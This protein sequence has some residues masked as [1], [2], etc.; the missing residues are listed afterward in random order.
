MVLLA[1]LCLPLLQVPSA[2]DFMPLIVGT[3]WTYRETG[4]EAL[5]F[6]HTVESSVR[7]SGQVATPVVVR[8]QGSP[9]ST[10]Y[11]VVNDNTLGIIADDDLRDPYS[12]PRPVFKVAAET[13]NW[14][15]AGKVPFDSGDAPI[16]MTGSSRLGQKQTVLGKE[17]DTLEVTLD[18]TLTPPKKKPIMQHQVAIYGK[19]IGLIE[20]T[21]TQSFN[22]EKHV[23]HLE[24]IKVQWPEIPK[25]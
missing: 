2:R 3:R 4:E 13:Q 25:G 20:M 22:G 17:V 6:V 23:Q 5:V 19:G 18:G 11:Y 7:V 9:L 12:P 24:L 15:Y 10:T 1:A 8:S 21:A 16:T 14:T